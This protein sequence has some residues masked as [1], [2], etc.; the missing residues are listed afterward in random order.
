VGDYAVDFA[1]YSSPGSY[2]LTGGLVLA[3]TT[4]VL[5][6]FTQ[7]GG[8]MSAGTVS[9]GS[10][11]AVALY[12]IDGDSLLSAKSIG[13]GGNL[14]K[15]G[16]G[17]ITQSGGT[18]AVTG[19]LV[20][21]ASGY[22]N[23]DLNSG[24]LIISSLAVNRGSG[25]FN[26]DGGTIQAGASFSS[27]APLGLDNP[28]GNATIDPAGY[29]VT[30]SGNLSGP[31]NLIEA[32]A[33][34][35]ILSGT[36]SYTGGTTVSGGEL[37]VTHSYCLYD[38]SNLIV[39]NAAAFAPLAPSAAPPGNSSAS[40]VPEPGTLAIV[41]SLALPLAIR[42]LRRRKKTDTAV[43]SCLRWQLVRRVATLRW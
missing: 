38:G 9:V 41:A 22:G 23:Y 7:S 37:V 36:N 3:K 18:V 29:K 31:G 2:S 19:A 5:G 4:S 25:A 34:T 27:S 21:G 11:L 16:T 32:G 1:P 13:L 39:G 14:S 33:G 43:H 35:L 26:F 42:G 20:I 12:S 15:T 8:T 6:T 28:G 24:D 10:D 17:T 40:P 30:L